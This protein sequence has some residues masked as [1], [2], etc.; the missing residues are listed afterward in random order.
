MIPGI[1]YAH[2]QGST[3]IECKHELNINLRRWKFG[4]Y[5][6]GRILPEGLALESG[7]GK[8]MVVRGVGF[9]DGHGGG[10]GDIAMVVG[11]GG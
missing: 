1:T 4:V 6:G 3:H 5:L 2:K 7:G 11:R 9:A 10:Y 8:L